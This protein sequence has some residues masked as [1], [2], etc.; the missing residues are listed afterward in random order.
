MNNKLRHVFWLFIITCL[1]LLY[2]V[3]YVA[4]G[5]KIALAAKR[6]LSFREQLD[7]LRDEYEEFTGVEWKLEVTT[8]VNYESVE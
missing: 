4:I 1:V 5:F 2:S 7:K 6:T 8:A 3:D